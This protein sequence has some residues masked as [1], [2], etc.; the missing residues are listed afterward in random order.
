MFHIYFV[1]ARK[2]PIVWS[3]ILAKFNR[4]K[5]LIGGVLYESYSERFFKIHR[6][7]LTLVSFFKQSCE[8]RLGPRPKQVRFY[9]F[10]KT[11]KI[12]NNKIKNENKKLKQWKKY[13]SEK[14]AQ[15]NHGPWVPNLI[16]FFFIQKEK[17]HKITMAHDCQ[18]S[19]LVTRLYI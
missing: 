12:K 17:K 3:C 2:L 13:Y 15:N 7:I 1:A 14:N 8:S 11:L 16:I 10:C 9:E 5:Y 18:I 6:K 4:Q 19:Y